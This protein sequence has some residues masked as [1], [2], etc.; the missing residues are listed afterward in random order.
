MF[1]NK[2]PTLFFQNVLKQLILEDTSEFDNF[3][4]YNVQYKKS[5]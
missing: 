2:T 3:H 1:D 5:G 4:H